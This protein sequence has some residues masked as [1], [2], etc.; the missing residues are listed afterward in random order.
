[1]K[2]KS[3][4]NVLLILLKQQNRTYSQFMI[5]PASHGH[6]F[7]TDRIASIRKSVNTKVKSVIFILLLYSYLV[8]I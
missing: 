2:G 5:S 7:S 8:E 4:G 6:F 1:M 3:C